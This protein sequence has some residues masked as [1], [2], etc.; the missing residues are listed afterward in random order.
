MDVASKVLPLRNGKS[1]DPS[2]N[3]EL[4]DPLVLLLG[5]CSR[6]PVLLLGS[7]SWAQLIAF[8]SRSLRMVE[9][10]AANQLPCTATAQ[11]GSSC[12]EQYCN[13]SLIF[14]NSLCTVV[15][16]AR[17]SIIIPFSELQ[18]SAESRNHCI[19]HHSLLMYCLH[20]ILGSSSACT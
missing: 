18:C 5:S 6:A 1:S 16:R 4:L 17:C 20:L 9:P 7:C 2:A 15:C 10:P 8:S 3:L 12:T 11:G 19:R 13:L 14:T